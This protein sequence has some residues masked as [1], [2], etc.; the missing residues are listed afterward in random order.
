MDWIRENAFQIVV[1]GLFVW[2]H[3][4]MHGKHGHGHG[5]H[6]AHGQHGHGKPEEPEHVHHADAE[7]ASAQISPHTEREYSDD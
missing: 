7:R 2:V 1:L 5:T 6:G 3:F 4:K